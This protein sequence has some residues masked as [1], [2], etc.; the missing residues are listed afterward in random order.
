[1]FHKFKVGD[2]VDYRHVNLSVES[3]KFQKNSLL[4]EI[5]DMFRSFYGHSDTDIQDGLLSS[6][7]ADLVFRNTGIRLKFILSTYGPAIQPP[8]MDRNN[9]LINNEYKGFYSSRDTLD[10]LSRSKGVLAGEVDMR[11]GKVSG[12][13]SEFESTCYL[14]VKEIIGKGML[15]PEELASTLLHEIGHVWSLFY[16]IAN[17]ARTNLAIAAIDRDYRNERDIT[18]RRAI[19]KKAIDVADIK[20]VDADALAESEDVLV[21]ETVLITNKVRQQRAL[22]GE[23]AGVYD[24]VNYEYMSDAYARAQGAGPYLSG[25]LEKLF[26]GWHISKRSFGTYFFV[27]LVKWSSLFLAPGVFFLLM[28]ID[29][30]PNNYDEPGYRLKRI[31][32]QLVNDSKNRKLPPKMLE[33]LM[34]DIAVVE[35]NIKEFS[36]HRQWYDILVTNLF[37]SMRRAKTQREFQRSLETLLNNEL[38]VRSNELK[39]LGNQK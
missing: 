14:P 21:V 20:D 35:A 36:D 8:Y 28:A 7:M 12:V 32:D 18:K 26:P 4:S 10:M 38:F 31:R 2:D 34:A 6:Q 39:L 9:P 17:T 30:Y 33:Q 37:P 19:L 5:A 24:E 3:F 13:F 16:C 15:S 27:E 11:T 25:A 29:S 22:L 23:A 1:M